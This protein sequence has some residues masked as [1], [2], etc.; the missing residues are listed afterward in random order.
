VRHPPASFV[1]DSVHP[2]FLEPSLEFAAAPSRAAAWSVVAVA[3]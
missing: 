2:V 1:V 3:T